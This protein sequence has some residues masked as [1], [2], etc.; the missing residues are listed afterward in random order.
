MSAPLQSEP[1][2]PWIA[3]D[4]RQREQMIKWV[5][6]RLDEGGGR[7]GLSPEHAA[8]LTPET[9]ARSI[10]QLHKWMDEGGPELE[11][12]QHGDIRA[13]R[14]LVRK[15]FPYLAD[16]LQPPKLKRGEKYEPYEIDGVIVPRGECYTDVKDKV[17]RKN[18]IAGAVADV[19]RIKRIWQDHYD[20][21]ANRGA[22]QVSAILIAAERHGVTADE[23]I[24]RQ[25]RP[26]RA[27]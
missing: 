2:P 10:K 24:E 27:K 15:V 5:N 16:L 13:A 1:L 7:R 23:V 25:K 19:T 9:L 14:E 22:D 21:R 12:A 17:E 26:S 6:A 8:R 3:R 20:G 11:L 18:Q 4:K